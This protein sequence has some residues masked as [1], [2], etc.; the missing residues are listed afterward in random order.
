[1]FRVVSPVPGTGSNRAVIR[2]G[3]TVRWTWLTN[4]HS[5]TADDN[6]FNT[7]VQSAGFVFTN[8]F[9]SSGVV[10]YF[11]YIHGSPGL[12]MWG[13][14]TAHNPPTDIQLSNTSVVEHTSNGTVVGAL[15]TIDLDPMDTFVYLLTDDAGGRFAINGNQLVVA[16]GALLDH[17]TNP[18]HFIQVT[19]T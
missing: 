12:G 4:T 1:N 17:V 8:T 9:T 5:V 2:V 10:G 7:Y 3:D 6:S 15:G 11:C 13:L 16:N 18:A 19:S 14:L